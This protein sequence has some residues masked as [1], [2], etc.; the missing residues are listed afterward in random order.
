[1][2]SL[3]SVKQDQFAKVLVVGES[4][5][6]KTGALAGL[7]NAGYNLR[8]LDF[9]RGAADVLLTY[10]DKDK[11]KN[12]DLV[13]LT[14]KLKTLG[15]NLVPDGVP[16]AFSNALKLLTDWKYSVV[17]GKLD[18]STKEP[19]I[20]FGPLE[21]WTNKD[22]LVIDSLTFM[23]QAAMTYCLHLKGRSGQQPWLEDWG[24]A[25]RMLENMLALIYSD[26]IRCNVVVNTHIR[27]L[28]SETAPTKGFPS[29]LGEKLPQKVGSY[30]NTML[31]AKTKGTG[32]SS[33]RIIMTRSQP[34]IELKLPL[35]DF[36]AEL[37]IEEA[38]P[39]IFNAM[40]NR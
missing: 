34:Q 37:D 12:V 23:G 22:V 36:P 19:E 24:N 15:P 40:C 18:L 13:V 30:F 16:K 31:L 4:G 14:D 28:E 8:I 3:E 2:P 20:D 33:K 35:K 39:R 21:T 17:D 29:A 6:G 11:I 27:L 32:T 7:V 9:D 25:V 38:L 10:C 1:M 5:T 26:S